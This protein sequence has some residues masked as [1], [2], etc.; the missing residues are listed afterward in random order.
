MGVCSVKRVVNEA[1]MPKM[2][3]IRTPPKAVTKKEEAPKSKSSPIMFSWP[4]LEK[5]S[6]MRYNT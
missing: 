2:M 3:P 1:R 5:P 6:N 4:I